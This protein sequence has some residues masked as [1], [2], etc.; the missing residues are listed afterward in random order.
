MYISGVVTV[1]IWC[2]GSVGHTKELELL[3]DCCD[4]T[5]MKDHTENKHTST[6]SE[7]L[8]HE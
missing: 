2:M 5:A 4:R 8:K 1:F 6:Q 7:V 3:V